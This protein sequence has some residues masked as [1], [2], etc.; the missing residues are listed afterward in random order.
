MKA[1]KKFI[2]DIE[3]KKKFILKFLFVFDSIII[4]K[5]STE[6][7]D[8]KKLEDVIQQLLEAM[9]ELVCLELLK[10]CS[11]EDIKIIFYSIWNVAYEAKERSLQ[12][13]CRNMLQ[14]LYETVKKFASYCSDQKVQLGQIYNEEVLV[15]II[16]RTLSL[17][18]DIHVGQKNFNA[19]RQA[20]TDLERLQ[21]NDA[22]TYI[23]KI[24]VLV[25]MSLEQCN[26]QPLNALS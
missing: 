7:F 10:S 2:I 25:Y 15:T 22:D 11:E 13:E 5:E 23:L 9:N 14:F 18:A 4:Q 1:C 21:R 8:E 26:D 19:A 16:Y 12:Q 20:I 24:R 6:N 3:L 17:L